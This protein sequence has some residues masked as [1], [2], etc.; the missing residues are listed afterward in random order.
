MGDVST[1]KPDVQALE[2][3]ALIE[4]YFTVNEARSMTFPANT[5][6][7]LVE[8]FCTTEAG[9]FIFNLA[10]TYLSE[11]PDGPRTPNVET[12]LLIDNSVVATA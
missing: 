5:E 7:T 6:S 11:D 9:V 2:A 1:L 8:E 3:A 12:M 10:V 4:D